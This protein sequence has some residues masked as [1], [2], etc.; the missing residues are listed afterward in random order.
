MKKLNLAQKKECILNILIY[1]DK[2]CSTYSLNYTLDAG[3][4]LGAARH[5]GF[6]P[7]DDDIDVAMPYEDYVKLIKLTPSINLNSRY[8]VRGFSKKEMKQDGYSYPFLKIEDT[9][10][11]AKFYKTCDNGGA[12]IDIFPLTDIPDSKI[13]FKRYA[14]ELIFLRKCLAASNTQYDKNVIKNAIRKVS[15]PFKGVFRDKMIAITKELGKCSTNQ[16]A[17][18]V[19]GDNRFHDIFPKT[20][21]NN[22]IDLEFEGHKFKAISN[23]DDYLTIEYGD[24]RKLPPKNE[25]KG[26]HFYDLFLKECNY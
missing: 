13:L 25:R 20:F 8:V 24:W 7:W 6:I 9:N 10:T 15:R 11:T 18:T 23:Y 19:W 22:Y 21:F 26:H 4:L 14:I 12:W 1:F 17:D 2:I 3:T 16:I 5:K